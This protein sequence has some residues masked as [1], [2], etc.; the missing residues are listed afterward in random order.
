MF[1]CGDPV[2]NTS[3]L[4]LFC[5]PRHMVP[6]AGV[7]VWGAI[8]CNTQSPLVLIRGTMIAQRYVQDIMQPHVLPLAQR[9]PGV[10]FQQDNARPHMARVSQGSLLT[11]STLPWLARPP[12]LSPIKD[13]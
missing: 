9:L 1:V 12:D 6:T 11:V 3:I 13:I 2:V 7:M 4:P 5:F 8:A 10:I